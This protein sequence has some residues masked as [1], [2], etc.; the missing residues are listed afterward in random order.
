MELIYLWIHKS[1]Y[2]CIKN[3]E[4]NFS[5]IHRFSVDNKDNPTSIKYEKCK[6][7]INF[8]KSD[9]ISNMTAIVGSNGVGKSSLL[10]FIANNNCYDKFSEKTKVEYKKYYNS[11]YE[12]EKSIYIFKDNNNFILYYNLENELNYPEIIKKEKDYHN[13]CE[14]ERIPMLCDMRSQMIIYLS[15]SYYV[16]NGLM[17]YSQSRKTYNINLHLQSLNLISNRFYKLLWG[18]E[19]F[20]KSDVK[21]DITAKIVCSKRNERTFQELLD[22]MY[23]SFL[24]SNGISD[25]LGK[26][27]S[28]IY[29]YFE[30]IL[31]LGENFYFDD[32]ETISYINSP[33]YEFDGCPDINLKHKSS[34]K[35]YNKQNEFLKKYNIQLL[36]KIR[37]INVVSVLYFNLLFEFFLNNDNFILH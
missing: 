15:N 6:N 8:M 1:A 13:I 14:N 36:E 7:E 21:N 17:Q 27:K 31:S 25:C 24:K 29:V 32:I 34:E 18:I 5:P 11:L 19:E 33:E 20:S 23:Y 30:N 37:R 3:Q 2:D 22:V 9:K 16:P 28:E 35:H 4:L 26:F 12:N 10:S